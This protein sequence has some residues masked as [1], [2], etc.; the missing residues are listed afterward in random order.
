MN[1][2]DLRSVLM[3][4]G[5]IRRFVPFAEDAMSI[6]KIPINYF[7]HEMAPLFCRSREQE[8]VFAED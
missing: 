1:G 4:V 3:S 5:P 7:A 2:L 8:S 6:T